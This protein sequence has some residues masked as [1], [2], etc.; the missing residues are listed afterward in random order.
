VGPFDLDYNFP[1]PNG[2]LSGMP[3]GVL[4]PRAM[5]LF[6][7][8]QGL[9]KAGG[10][11][12][13]PTGLGQALGSGIQGGLQ[14]FI[15]AQQLNDQSA[16]RQIQVSKLKEEQEAKKRQNAAMASIAN[17]PKY[18]QYL[19]LIQAGV[20][21]KDILE[22]VSP[23][24]QPFSLRPGER[25]FNEAGQQ[26]AEAPDKE[27]DFT[28]ALKLAGIPL[29]SPEG[30]RLA[31]LRT[32]KLTSHPPAAKV[33][34]RVDNKTGDSLARPIGEIVQGT[35]SVALGGL[36]QI[37]TGHRILDALDSGK[38]ITGPG[39]KART[40]LKQLGVTYGVN[41]KDD[42]EVLQNTRQVVKG[43]AEFTLGA[44]KQL[45]G[46]GQV[47]DYEGKLIEKAASGDIE[48]M[49]EPEI[50]SVVAVA[51]RLARKGHELHLRQIENIK[52]N[53]GLAPLAD[54]YGVPDLPAPRAPKPKAVEPKVA[55]Q[56]GDV[57]D[58]WEFI[59]GDPAQ[60]INWRKK[61]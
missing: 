51:D 45:K 37:E 21:L 30:Q 31:R 14:S 58:G 24:P 49:T 7:L 29:D 52:K 55:P 43:L 16:L 27:D 53:P 23:K 11:S 4:D 56:K 35:Q 26:I 10:P 36:D 19:P 6:G 3:T 28:K 42:A 13:T 32:E 48:D 38:V 5:A 33:D 22:R 39:A 9:L 17:D 59:G 61:K 46:Q 1:N 41:G 25:R 44:R 60:R 15:Q 2:A 40:F 12:A 47:S 8:S 57:V 54:F 34:V 50:R 20:P 18:Q